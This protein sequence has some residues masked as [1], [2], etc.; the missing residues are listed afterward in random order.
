MENNRK[1]QVKKKEN[2]K[3]MNSSIHEKVAA[4]PHVFYDIAAINVK[5]REFII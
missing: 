2:Q 5:E 4:I 1:K 3:G